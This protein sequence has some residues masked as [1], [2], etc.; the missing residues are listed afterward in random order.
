MIGDC[1][2]AGPEMSCGINSQNQ[3]R[4]KKLENFAYHLKKGKILFSFTYI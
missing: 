1:F 3:D 4:K 2:R